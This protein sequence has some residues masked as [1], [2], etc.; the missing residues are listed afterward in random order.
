MHSGSVE[1]SVQIDWY[2]YIR[3]ND[4]PRDDWFI[5]YA[6][7]CVWDVRQEDS[8]GEYAR[9]ICD[10]SWRLFLGGLDTQ[11][12]LPISTTDW[13]S[14]W[15]RRLLGGSGRCSCMLVIFSSSYCSGDLPRRLSAPCSYLDA[16]YCYLLKRTVGRITASLTGA[17]SNHSVWAGDL[18]CRTLAASVQDWSWPHDMQK[19]FHSAT[20]A[21]SDGSVP[22]ISGQAEARNGL[23][24]FLDVQAAESFRT[25]TTTDREWC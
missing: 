7:C 2:I 20:V 24:L 5:V 3:A 9:G 12:V 19:W 17:L 13:W 18:S 11:L 23:A 22:K 25:S 14:C 10:R 4:R 21:R 6:C 1:W 16:C 8:D 15:W